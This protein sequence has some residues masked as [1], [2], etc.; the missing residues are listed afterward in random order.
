M[1][2]VSGFGRC[3][4]SMTM[5]M[6]HAGGIECLGEWPSFEHEKAMDLDME[7]L[8]AQEGKALKVLDP[9]RNSLPRGPEYKVIWLDRNTR[10]QAMSAINLLRLTTGVDVGGA[11]NIKNL[12]RSYKKDRPLAIAALRRTGAAILAMRFEDLLARPQEEA[13]RIAVFLGLNMDA[14]AMAG[15]V[16]PRGP[17]CRPDLLMAEANRL[18]DFCRADAPM[19]KVG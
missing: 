7:W 16:I 10:Q 6:L 8:R 19:E 5:Q 17:E 9:Q 14:Q 4:S 11:V 15:V 18:L 12:M 2:I 3:G 1:I 13:R